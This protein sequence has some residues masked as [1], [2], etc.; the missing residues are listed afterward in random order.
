MKNWLTASMTALVIFFAAAASAI[1][2]QEPEPHHYTAAEVA[3]QNEDGLAATAVETPTVL[4]LYSEAN[5]RGQQLR[6]EVVPA[7]ARE[8]TRTITT[9]QLQ[10]AGLLSR[11]SSA[12]LRC[13]TRDSHVMLYTGR[14]SRSVAAWNPSG[15]GYP[16]LCSARTTTLVNLHTDARRLADNVGAVYLV[17]HAPEIRAADLSGLVES[18]WQRLLRDRLPDGASPRGVVKL[19]F[20]GSSSFTL[21][22]ELKLD[23]WACGGRP[24]HLELV[25][26]LHVSGPTTAEPT[27]YFDVNPGSVWVDDSWGDA[28][29]CRD[30]MLERLRTATDRAAAQL[31]RALERLAHGL[32][33]DYTR[34]YMVPTYGLRHFWLFGGRVP[35][36]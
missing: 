33:P 30:R 26:H 16:I 31:E 10:A 25:A 34:Y 29:G 23:H 1:A 14:S 13:G 18:N 7:R 22:Q 27:D 15:I 9:P 35:A 36:E 5:F 28:W 8:A 3:T 4:I 24:A 20:N 6:T 19:E 12:R 11:V 21:A 17:A 32:V 2:A